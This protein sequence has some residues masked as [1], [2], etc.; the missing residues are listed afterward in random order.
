[1]SKP[2]TD[3]MFSLKNEFSEDMF[4]LKEDE[5]EQGSAAAFTEDMF[6][7]APEIQ[8]PQLSTKERLQQA[9][10]D[11]QTG[12]LP[13]EAD[14]DG[15]PT[16][17]DMIN[18]DK[19]LTE[20][21]MEY[22]A[23]PSRRRVGM[24][25]IAKAKQKLYERESALLAMASDEGRYRPRAV[26]VR[27]PKYEEVEQSTIQKIVEEYG[28]L[29]A[30]FNKNSS[31][32]DKA[33][34][35]K[36]V[37]QEYDRAASFPIPAQ[38][39]AGETP[40]QE[41]F[42][43]NLFSP[44]AVYAES[45]R[46]GRLQPETSKELM[47]PNSRK[48]EK[49]LPS[50]FN[51][52]KLMV[53]TLMTGQT[54]EQRRPQQLAALR[55]VTTLS[56]MRDMLDAAERGETIRGSSVKMLNQAK[57]IAQQKPDKGAEDFKK[58]HF[59]DILDP[60]RNPR[61]LQRELVD[62]ADVEFDSVQFLGNVQRQLVETVGLVPAAA[63]YTYYAI[64][65]D[66]NVFDDVATFAPAVVEYMA[67][68][69]K[70]PSR[71]AYNYPLDALGLFSAGLGGVKFA[72]SQ[73]GK[74]AGK[75]GAKS[76][77]KGLGKAADGF[78]FAYNMTNP[79]EATKAVVGARTRKKFQDAELGYAKGYGEL[80]ADDI[81]KIVKR[82]LRWLD[83]SE[84]GGM[85]LV[86][87]DGR[88]TTLHDMFKSKDGAVSK[89]IND[90][91]NTMEDF[92]A[93]FKNKPELGKETLEEMRDI[94]FGELESGSRLFVKV[95]DGAPMQPGVKAPLIRAS[96]STLDD[97]ETRR[98]VIDSKI[99]ELNALQEQAP[100]RQVTAEDIERR[101]SLRKDDTVVDF[102]GAD[103]I[104]RRIENMQSEVANELVE[105]R[106]VIRQAYDEHI[107]S[108]P[109]GEARLN[110]R[111][112]D[113]ATAQDFFVRPG[114]RLHVEVID[115][116]KIQDVHFFPNEM[117]N[118]FRYG[119]VT[120]KVVDEAIATG[121]IASRNTMKELVD[122]YANNRPVGFVPDDVI[123][124]AYNVKLFDELEAT[125]QLELDNGRQL[126]EATQAAYDDAK[127]I[128][129]VDLLSGE[130][131]GFLR[132][133]GDTFS[134]PSMKDAVGVYSTKMPD[135]T[136]QHV[137]QL[138]R[139][140]RSAA[141]IRSRF[142]A[143]G[144]RAVELGLLDEKKY[145]RRL[146]EYFPHF[147]R[148]EKRMQFKKR[149]VDG[150][151]EDLIRKRGAAQSQDARDFLDGKLVEKRAERAEIEREFLQVKE[152][153]AGGPS[154]KGKH[155]KQEKLAGLSFEEK[156]ERGLVSNP[157][158]AGLQGI[159][160][161]TNDVET[162]YFHNQLSKMRYAEDGPMEGANFVSDK[163]IRPTWRQLPESGFG[164][165]SGKYVAP[166]VHYYLTQAYTASTPKALR[167]YMETLNGWKQYATL[168][169]PAGH[170]RNTVSNFGMATLAGM[171]PLIPADVKGK[172]SSAPRAWGNPFKK[173]S[174]FW[175]AWH[176]RGPDW[177]AAL[178]DGAVGTDFTQAEL[179][180]L[181]DLW[182]DA[183]VDLKD[184]S[185]GEIQA[186]FSIANATIR[187]AGRMLE[188]AVKNP[189][190]GKLLGT[191]LPRFLRKMYQFEENVFKLAR[192]RQIRLLHK[193]F[194]ETGRVTM[195]MSR[196]F[197]SRDE[198][199]KALSLPPADIGRQ[200]AKEANKWFFDYGDTSN[201]VNNVRNYYAPFIT[202]QYK[203]LPLIAKWMHGNPAQAFAYRRMFETFN[204][205]TEYM[206]GSEMSEK[207]FLER[208]MER[209]ALP[210]YI[211]ET[212]IRLPIEERRKFSGGFGEREASQ[213]ADIQFYT[214]AGGVVQRASGYD[215]GLF[216][217]TLSLLS[218]S[219][220]LITAAGNQSYNKDSFTN[221]E[222]VTD[223][224]DRTDQLV[225]R[226]AQ[227]GRD[228]LPPHLRMIEAAFEVAEQKP[229]RGIPGIAVADWEEYIG[230]K[231]FGFKKRIV[232]K[233]DYSKAFKA[234]QRQKNAILK[235]YSRKIKDAS[236]RDADPEE[237][238][239]IRR[240]VER[241]IDR[242]QTRFQSNIT[243]AERQAK[244]RMKI[245]KGD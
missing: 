163:P 72:L 213:Y 39:V 94:L 146:S 59:V 83:P 21:V 158:Q 134:P 40:G 177:D 222:I 112:V 221:R 227:L 91:Q 44:E 240:K 97:L 81:D 18:S 50:D 106:N 211:R 26:A 8:T 65:N 231:L 131:A 155:F 31:A 116:G 71:F 115:S 11:F 15:L 162:A 150:E 48:K 86:R 98:V 172:L 88:K 96:Q 166:D 6:S 233:G 41:G 232:M 144:A 187:A 169:N 127:R 186:P 37:R 195:E 133:V 69:L 28:E 126:D 160:N 156:L 30:N 25:E 4:S 20:S 228:I 77:S 193:E 124:K 67:E 180:V 176:H 7:L 154:S 237:I 199:V 87:P 212:G 220:P 226:G 43:T 114:D 38:T 128:A 75:V 58:R 53:D 140:Q 64:K 132:W 153:L 224:M 80:Q 103:P 76:L 122:R 234:Y 102:T 19:S 194:M 35:D 171:N 55:E 32:F 209:R 52:S 141:D 120:R 17:I 196:V 57:A 70:T 121:G 29:P 208:E 117:Y 109:V 145:M 174:A 152:E 95:P 190:K 111:Y 78:E 161:L 207:D 198:A 73:T 135:G 68:E 164:P 181:D 175:Q 99:D 125:R 149:Q 1:M 107:D 42:T 108:M 79:V 219:N 157:L 60:E 184:F 214:P 3:D 113:A 204:L 24:E 12:A 244:R 245:V 27:S 49:F 82:K 143:L 197:G 85:V 203:A 178:K 105:Y 93:D 170:V 139:P 241:Q 215:E 129:E 137:E 101:P 223:G 151:I 92:Q 235:E 66:R 200:A 183:R 168:L 242:L 182:E 119:D 14:E 90:A 84:L 243:E 165:I 239:E 230:D 89:A 46:T 56:A 147:Y 236:V 33:A 130:E 74:A 217:A 51:L 191:S 118:K 45:Q 142:L 104:L 23:E 188:T 5:E 179:G 22:A 218:M 100:K 138:S 61:E 9:E 136:L 189:T 47:D 34:F 202:F 167:Y 201:V 54:P 210:E 13:T 16:L 63:Y 238:E 173:N 2:F 36:R 110:S 225:A 205:M 185:K 229:A 123:F 216:P 148:L 159:I 10:S 206:N 62:G 192:Y